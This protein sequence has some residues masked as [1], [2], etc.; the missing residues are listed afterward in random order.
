MRTPC[1]GFPR[2]WEDT[3]SGCGPTLETTQPSR[4]NTGRMTRCAW[5]GE[6]FR[7]TK[8]GVREYVAR[9]PKRIFPSLEGTRFSHLWRGEVAFTMDHL[10][11]LGVHFA[12]GC[13]AANPPKG[14]WIGHRVARRIFGNSESAT[15]C[16]A[17]RFPILPGI[18]GYPWF[19]PLLTIWAR[20]RDWRGAA[21][22]GH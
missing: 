8:T 6:L 7:G 15:P 11:H 22:E 10:P 20:G 16:V 13:N 2:G 17:R 21:A 19:M 18:L 3:I 4:Q 5:P 1:R 14:T 12:L 9:G